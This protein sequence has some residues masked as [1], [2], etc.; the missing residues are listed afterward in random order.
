MK[1]VVKIENLYEEGGMEAA[2]AILR[3]EGIAL[4]AVGSSACVRSL[5]FTAKEMGRLDVLF[6]RVLTRQDYSLGKQEGAI[7]KCVQEALTRLDIR[8]V[9][10]YASCMDIL[11]GLDA[12]AIMAEI[13]N[14]KEIPVEILYRGPLAKRKC[15]PIKTLEWI[16]ERWGVKEQSDPESGTK[17]RIHEKKRISA[18]PMAPDFETF[19]ADLQSEDCDILLLTPG[20][21]K[22]CMACQKEKTFLHVKNTCFSD[23]S[24]WNY[25]T[26]GIIDPILKSF[27]ENKTLYL[28]SSMVMDAIGFDVEELC[29]QLQEKGKNAVYYKGAFGDLTAEQII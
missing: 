9:I 11:T 4:V 5:Y 15:P 29:Y 27:P 1:N 12:D 3:K 14:P 22:S 28:I 16:W 7:Q 20:G 25:K 17:E 19:I 18:P 23:L 21:C 10:V 13:D 6:W 26:E 8:G 2:K 24:V